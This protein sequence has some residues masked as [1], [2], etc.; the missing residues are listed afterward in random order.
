[1]GEK[2]K[3]VTENK[4]KIQKEKKKIAEIHRPQPMNK[5]DL[6][7]RKEWRKNILCIFKKKKKLSGRESELQMLQTINLRGG[8]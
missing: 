2:L 4:R 6:L 7:L 1:M 8:V 3:L 5:V